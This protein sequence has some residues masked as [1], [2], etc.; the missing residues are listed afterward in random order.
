MTDARSTLGISAAWT[1]ALLKY[2]DAAPLLQRLSEECSRLSGGADYGEALEFLQGRPDRA[3]YK[4]A[5]EQP[6]KEWLESSWQ[7]VRRRYAERDSRLGGRARNGGREAGT[8][9]D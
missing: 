4:E 9:A 5:W 2:A 8:R 7:M 1:L 3:A 6:V